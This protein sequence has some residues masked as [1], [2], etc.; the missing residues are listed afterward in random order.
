MT[1]CENVC[2]VLISEMKNYFGDDTRRINHA[3]AVLDY[4]GQI[5]ETEGGDKV[6]IDSAA[7]LHDIGIKVAEQKYNSAAGKYQEIEGPAVAEEIL[8]RI[9][10]NERQIEHICMIIGNHHSA[11]CEQTKEFEAIWDADWIVNIPDEIG[12]DDK[13]KLRRIIE[14]VFKTDTGKMIARQLYLDGD[15]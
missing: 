7:I 11:K 14:K 4:A 1:D 3:L 15:C 13:D 5:Q 12:T 9:G 2:D 10:F 6:I 8:K